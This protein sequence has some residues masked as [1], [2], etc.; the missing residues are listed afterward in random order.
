IRLK[1]LAAEN[2]TDISVVVLEKGSEAG[3]HILSGAVIDPVGLNA[4]LPNWREEAAPV[5]QTV[6][7]DRFLYLGPSGSLRLPNFILP[8]LMSNHGN[9]IV[10]LGDLVRWLASKAEELGVA[11]YPGFPA[12]EILTSSEGAVI[13]VATGD[14][15]V[16]RDGKPK[17]E[18]AR[19]MALY[20]KYTL[21]AEGAR[22]SLSKKLIG[23]FDLDVDCEPQKFG[24]G[25][26]ELWQVAPE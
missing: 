3:A 10:S 20:G 26:K 14:L 19:G 13:G 9:Y 25:L 24:I 1:Q 2:G 5:T 8:P 11:I 16:G 15:G 6:T 18:F 12:A 17:T 7:K 22:G 4:L 21:F 23:M